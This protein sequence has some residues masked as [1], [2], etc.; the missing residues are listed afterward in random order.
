M[1]PVSVSIGSGGPR[2]TIGLTGRWQLALCHTEEPPATFDHQIDVPSV[3]DCAEPGLHG[4]QAPYYWYA[5][6]LQ[7]EPLPPDT[8]I[9]L[10]IEQAQ[11]GTSVWVDDRWAGSS[12][13]CMT[14]QE[15]RI[16]PL[17]RNG[18]HRLAVRVGARTTLPPESAAGR[19]QEKE[20]YTP[21]IWGDVSLILTGPAHL[22]DILL[23]PDLAGASV[24]AKV[25]VIDAGQPADRLQVHVAVN[26]PDGRPASMTAHAVLVRDEDDCRFFEVRIPLTA[27]RAWSPEDPALYTAHVSV[28]VD[29]VPAD[30][31]AVRFGM[32]DFRIVGR[33]FHLNG[34]PRYLRGGNIAFHR[35]LSDPERRK[36][37]WTMEWVRR[38]LIDIPLEHHF[39]FFRFHLG[40]AYH[41]W[42]DLADEHGMLLQDEWPFWNATGSNAAIAREFRQW[43]KDHGNHPSIVI[44]DP[45]NES[46]DDSLI[47]DVV[48]LLRELDPTRPWEA[49]DFVEQH[50]YIYSLGMTLNHRPFGY[51]KAL[52]ELERSCVPVVVNEFLWWWFDASW[53]PTIL[54]KEVVERWLG[55][56][57]DTGAIIRRQAYLA[58]ELVGLFRRMRCAAIQPFVYLSNNEGPTAHWFEGPIGDLRP[59]PVLAALKNAFA[60]FGLSIDHPDRHRETSEATSLLVHVFNDTSQV[61]H[62]DVT[63]SLQAADGSEDAMD[64]VPVRVPPGGRATVHLSLTMPA[65]PGTT[66]VR[67]ELMEGVHVVA[68]AQRVIHVLAR[69]ARRPVPLRPAVI[70]DPGGEI[71][72]FLERQG[73]DVRPW[74]GPPWPEEAVFF[75][76]SFG[77][78]HRAYRDRIDAIG[79]RV[80]DGATLVVQEPEFRVVEPTEL[81]VLPGLHLHVSRRNDIDKGG[82]DSYVF[83]EDPAHTLWRELRPEH[84]QWFNGGVGGEIVSEYSVEPSLPSVRL[85]S[86]GLGLR[87]PAVF[88]VPVGRGRVVVSRIQVRGRLRRSEHSTDPFARRYDPVAAQYLLNLLSL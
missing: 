30:A 58:E 49:V 46:T 34:R 9:W 70:L 59:K 75:V 51:A 52:P 23:L 12:D 67:C 3:V 62:G 2:T 60:P 45:L 20:V 6:D 24:T 39:N 55:R 63:A 1:N 64:P 50:P 65:T 80:N 61:R 10:R 53:S 47:H 71:L 76:G 54:M 19:D 85:A 43:I 73:T 22:R 68:T 31:G 87:V 84:F 74:E 37:P 88:E 41:R 4:R 25:W 21:G 33:E 82:Y 26:D 14:S 11:F 15:Y 78:G 42:Y 48:P 35:F 16:D 27:P 13:A 17:F 29:G 36:L 72:E 81:Q 28:S 32:R 38:L 40:P 18:E 5:R 57:A 66:T 79:S 44:W 69:Q 86:C 77:L 7:I 8:Q 56:G 83:P